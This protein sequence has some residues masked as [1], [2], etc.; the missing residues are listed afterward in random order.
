MTPL[1]L[2]NRLSALDWSACPLAHQLAVSAAVASLSGKPAPSNVVAFP[3]L[4][5]AHEPV[6]SLEAKDEN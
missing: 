3:R 1:E 4:P 6:N 5:G 2:A